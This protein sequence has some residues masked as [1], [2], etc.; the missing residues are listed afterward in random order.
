[1]GENPGQPSKESQPI[2]IAVMPFTNITGNKN[3][4]WLSIGISESLCTKLGSLPCF[5]LV[6][7][8][9][10]S[11]ALKEIELGQVGLINE[12]TA[13][14][15]GKM[16]GAEELLVGSFQIVEPNIRISARFV[17]VESGKIHTMVEATGKL[18]Q[19]FELQDKIV[20]SFLANLNIPVTDEE[21]SVLTAKPTASPQAFKLYSQ[22]M[23]TYT[24]EGKALG[25]DQRIVLLNQ[26]TQIDANFAPAYTSLGDIYAQRK[27]DYNRA[28]VYYNKVVVLQ[29][30]IIAPRVRL[31]HVYQMQ[32]NTLA[33]QQEKKKIE[34]MKRSLALQQADRQR[35]LEE[36]RRRALLRAQ[37]EK[38]KA[39]ELEKR[40]DQEKQLKAQELERRRILEE[41]HKAQELE[42]RRILEEKRRAQEL[43]R[44]RI[45]EEKLKAL[46]LEKRRILEEK[47]KA[48]E[49]E[50]RRMQEE[51]L[52][53]LEL[54]R[55]RILE[56][57]HKAKEK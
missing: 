53:A 45:L 50:K 9:K 18:D 47:P 13:A 4:D 26:S 23:D 54:E 20:A 24:P 43:E 14:K 44:R 55:R 10:L 49:L 29:P 28:A 52:K 21:K 48:R 36:R 7:R 42:R 39:Q 40:R 41:K 2:I 3:Y 27:Q 5:S 30:R 25:D 22:A 32:G 51:K 46:E 11:E 31:V 38:R 35:I 17:E 33:L 57:M 19:I 15:T 37:E 6:E 1:M 8:V 34:E 12:T 56:E 16:A